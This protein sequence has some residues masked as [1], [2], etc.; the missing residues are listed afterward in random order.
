MRAI[1][2]LASH[3]SIKYLLISG[4]WADQTSRKPANPQTRKPA[5]PQTRKPANP[6]TRKPA[7][8]NASAKG[9]WY[10]PGR[11]AAGPPAVAASPAAPKKKRLPRGQPF[12]H[13]IPQRCQAPFGRI[14]QGFMR[15]R[16]SRP[17]FSTFMI[18]PARLMPSSFA[19][20]DLFQPV[21]R[22]PSLINSRSSSS[23]A[24]FSLP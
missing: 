16:L 8:C 20:F 22:R 9:N 24:S 21:R 23:R 14:N 11:R 1:L 17:Y 13:R 2:F 12:P 19:S 18:K 15:R 10:P 6:Q 7:R 4:T 3:E 5:N